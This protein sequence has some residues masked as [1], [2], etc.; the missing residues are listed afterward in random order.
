VFLIFTEYLIWFDW[1]FS[2][3]VDRFI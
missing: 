2:E 1:D 3:E